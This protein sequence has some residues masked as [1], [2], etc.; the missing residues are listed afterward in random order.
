[1]DLTAFDLVLFDCQQQ[2]AE[3]FMSVKVREIVLYAALGDKSSL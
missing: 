2:V 1:M 3:G